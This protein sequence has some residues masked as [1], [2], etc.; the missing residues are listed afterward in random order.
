MFIGPGLEERG[1]KKKKLYLLTHTPAWAHVIMIN[2]YDME[3]FSSI[4]FS[5][6]VILGWSL[7][8]LRCFWQYGMESILHNIVSNFHFR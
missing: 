6:I 5:F 8:S 7:D 2:F 1:C 3:C 4:A